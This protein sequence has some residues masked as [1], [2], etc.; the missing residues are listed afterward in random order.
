MW[1]TRRERSKDRAAVHAVNLAAFPTPD[2]AEL[3]DALRADGGAWVDL[4]FVVTHDD[5]VVGHALLTRCHVDGAPA[6]ALAPCAVLPSHQGRG[7][8]AAAIRAALGAA[9]EAG[10]NLVVVLGHAG[11][12]PRFGFAPASTRGVRAPFDVPDEAFMALALDAS[13]P[14]PTGTVAYPS[15][16]GV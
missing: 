11:Y 15:A 16:F 9:R 1:S 14:V 7:A 2:E 4:S 12:Y 3:V 8:G 13:R 6:L 5:E 10:E